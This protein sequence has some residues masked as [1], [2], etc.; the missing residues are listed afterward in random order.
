MAVQLK[1]RWLDAPTIDQNAARPS[2]LPVQ[3]HKKLDPAQSQSQSQALKKESSLHLHG[4]QQ[5]PVLLP[6]A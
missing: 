3:N 5:H 4:Q 2:I 1:C 6:Q